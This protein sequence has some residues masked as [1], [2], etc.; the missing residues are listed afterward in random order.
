MDNPNRVVMKKFGG[1]IPVQT[2]MAAKKF[3]IENGMT[4]NNFYDLAIRTY[5]G[6]HGTTLKEN[7]HAQD[8]H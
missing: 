7:C 8:N 6:E 2:H 3:V 1:I 5:L 4:L